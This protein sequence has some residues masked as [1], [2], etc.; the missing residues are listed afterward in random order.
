VVA[1]FGLVHGAYHGAWCWTELGS[2]LTSLGHAVVAVDLPNEDPEAGAQR[3]AQT[4]VS[5]LDGIDGDIVLV[6]HSLAGLTIP[7]IATLRPVRH[8]VYLCAL[9]PQPGASFDQLRTS[10]PMFS[11]YRAAVA[12]V[13]HSD[14]SASCPAE[15]AIELFYH[16]CAPEVAGWAASQLSRQHWRIMQEITPLIEFADLPA[17]YIVCASDRAVDPAW[18]RAAARRVLGVEPIELGGGHSPF[19]TQPARLAELLHA[20]LS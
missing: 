5:G 7:V 15:R 10:T 1:T 19:L 8:L 13:S 20:C 6:G 17:S 16:D 14:G 2:H 12:A 9:L 3:Y 11:H 4:V 18:S